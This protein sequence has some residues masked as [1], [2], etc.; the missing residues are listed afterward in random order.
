M[1]RLRRLEVFRAVAAASSFTGAGV[2]LELS[3]PA[4][5][6]AIGDLERQFGTPLFERTTRSVVL[7]PQGR[8]LLGLSED[9]LDRFDAAMDRFA[10]YCRGDR[11]SVV[12]AAL[13]SVAAGL[14]PSVLAGFL[15]VYPSVGVEILDV[16][17]AEA[18][19]HLR[20][21]RADVALVEESSAEEFAARR[22]HTD[23]MVAVLPEHHPL[24]AQPS[25]RW[26][27][28]AHQPF[29][30][31]GRG[32][33]VRRLT[34]LAFS[35]AGVSPSTV[36]EA[37]NIATAGGLIEAGLGVSAMPELALPLV[38]FAPLAYRELHDPLVSRN[39]A[40]L[41]RPDGPTSPPARRFL[42]ALAAHM[43]A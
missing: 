5:S 30:A 38:A 26:A 16:T 32:S 13:P 9:L 4:V 25:L 42:D 23:R 28:L 18:K 35:R 14:L 11:G 31:L 8:E 19:L 10:A 21:G 37:R 20:S 12:I 41:T 40:A 6:R 22:L 15:A 39:I 34:D 27:E 3:Q 24:A 2:E 33:S 1:D 17:T 36:V 43:V 29:I 7:T